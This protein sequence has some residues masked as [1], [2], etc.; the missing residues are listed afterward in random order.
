ME[1]SSYSLGLTINVAFV[2]HIYTALSFAVQH[3]ALH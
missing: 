2:K 3:S 1:W